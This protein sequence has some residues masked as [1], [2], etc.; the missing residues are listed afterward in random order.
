[1]KPNHSFSL[2]AL[3]QY[4]RDNKLNKAKVRLGMKREEM[5]EALKLLGE[6]DDTIQPKVKKPVVKKPVVKKVVVKKPVVKTPPKPVK[7]KLDKDQMDFLGG[8]T[9]SGDSQKVNNEKSIKVLK[10]IMKNYTGSNKDYDY[11]GDLLKRLEQSGFYSGKVF[12]IIKDLKVNKDNTKITYKLF[13]EVYDKFR[14][15]QILI[16]P[17]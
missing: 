12:S 3:K 6:W 7:K 13:D 10:N 14:P 17:K 9:D 4:I 16:E 8:I 11:V 1:M 5:I 2:K 15:R